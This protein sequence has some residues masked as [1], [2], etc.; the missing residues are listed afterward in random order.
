MPVLNRAPDSMDQVLPLAY[1]GAS[2]AGSMN[3]SP[4]YPSGPG[5]VQGWTGFDEDDE[6]QLAIGRGAS[7]PGAKQKGKEKMRDCWQGIL[8][9]AGLKK[10]PL[11]G[12]RKIFIGDQAKN[13]ASG[14]SNNYVST[15]KYNLVTFLPKFLFGRSI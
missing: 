2:P 5:G 8:E 12:E 13:A 7:G 9:M 14:F 6:E 3:K 10:K 15:S 11:T 1:S 4:I